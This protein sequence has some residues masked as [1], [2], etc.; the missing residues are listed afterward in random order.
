MHVVML[1]T[2][3]YSPADISVPVVRAYCRKWRY[4]LVHFDNVIRQE[5]VP[6]WNKI[7]AL[8]NTMHCAPRNEWIT[9]IDADVLLLRDDLRLESFADTGRHLVFSTDVGGLCTGFFM[10][11][12]CEAMEAFLEHLCSHYCPTWPWEQA[13]I[14]AAISNNTDL[15][16]ITSYL[17]TAV[18]QN[19][20][21][22]FN[23]EAFAMHYWANNY[24]C[25]SI[26][27]LMQMTIDNGWRLETFPA[28]VD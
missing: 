5:W 9:W 11:R 17:S 7:L 26:S 6:S 20:R 10:I 1:H 25:L 16:S 13:A 27:K 22:V 4:S 19:P 18:I 3:T 15:N 2:P 28:F 23:I 14:K 12:K 24:G 21:S 8:Q